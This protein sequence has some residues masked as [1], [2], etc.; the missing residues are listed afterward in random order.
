MQQPG[1]LLLLDVFAV[2]VKR[3]RA[4][5]QQTGGPVLGLALFCCKRRG[6]R[7]V[8]DTLHLHNASTEHTHTWYNALRELLAGKTGIISRL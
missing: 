7:L 2:K 3:R 4:A 8:E 5:G 6:R 1:V